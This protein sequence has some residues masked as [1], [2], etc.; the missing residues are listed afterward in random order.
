MICQVR[1]P[2]LSDFRRRCPPAAA[3][4]GQ[5]KG[6]GSATTIALAI[7]VLLLIAINLK[8]DV[9]ALRLLYHILE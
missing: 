1:S 4:K 6:V 2:L 7:G 3:S 8:L 5:H 9:F